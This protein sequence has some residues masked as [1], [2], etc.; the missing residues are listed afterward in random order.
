MEMLA[1]KVSSKYTNKNN[2]GLVGLSPLFAEKFVP[3]L[4]RPKGIHKN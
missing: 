3:H 4:F 1:T 2:L